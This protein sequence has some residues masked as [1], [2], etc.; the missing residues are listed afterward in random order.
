MYKLKSIVTLVGCT[1]GLVGCINDKDQ[2]EQEKID[3]Y[4]FTK[5]YNN[6]KVPKVILQPHQENTMKEII[7]A[8]EAFIN[9]NETQHFPTINDY[10]MKH[11]WN[12]DDFNYEGFR[13]YIATLND[14]SNINILFEHNIYTN[15]NIHQ[16]YI[17]NLNKEQCSYFI[18]YYKYNAKVR[19]SLKY[20]RSDI[21]G[22]SCEIINNNNSHNYEIK[23]EYTGKVFG[24]YYFGIKEAII[25]LI[26]KDYNNISS[27]YHANTNL[28]FTE[29][30]VSYKVFRDG[31]TYA[32]NTTNNHITIGAIDQEECKQIIHYFPENTKYK[33]NENNECIDGLNIIEIF[34]SSVFNIT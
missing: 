32:I 8:F 14:G 31:V 5:K 16:I 20:H 25:S 2:L 3:I 24:Y 30:P 1:I 19:S 4:S 23:I 6:Q 29:K 18:E 33:I 13:R 28:Y 26:N 12:I 27:G 21:E 34:K 22:L 10:A 7:N 9:E 17:G 11:N 15:Q